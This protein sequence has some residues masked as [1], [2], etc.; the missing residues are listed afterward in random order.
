MLAL[1]SADS[2]AVGAAAGP[3][4]HALHINFTQLGLLVALPA[5]TGAAATV[6]I[7]ALTDRVRRVPLL[8]FSIGLW[9]V[10]MIV[11]GAS[12]SFQMLLLSRLLLGAVTATS[13]PTIASLTGDLFPSLERA[14]IYGFILTGELLGSVVGLLISGNVAGLLSWRF[15]FWV[16]AIPGAALAWMIWRFLPEPVRGGQS[17]L[18]RG[19]TQMITGDPEQLHDARSEVEEPRRTS[20]AM[21]R[22][23]AAQRI[24][25]RAN[26][27]LEAD[28]D[29]MSL[30][31]AVRYVL[32]VP[33]NVALIVVSALGYFF[34]S[35]VRTFAVIFVGYQ[36]SIGQGLAT[37][38]LAVLSVGAVA[39]V[40][41]SGRLAD[42]LVERGH[43]AG[44]LIVAGGAFLLTSVLFLPP[45]L[46]RSLVIGVPF[47]LVATAALSAPNPP[48]DAARLDVMP[49]RLWG[50]AEG[51]RT[52][53]RSVA[54]AFAPLVFGFL[55]DRLGAGSRTPGEQT[56]LGQ[57][58]HA[59]GLRDTF[60]IVLVPLA[61]SG[62]ILLRSRHAYRRDVA[63]AL[64]GEQDPLAGEAPAV[65][66]D[67]APAGSHL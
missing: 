9:S 53:L 23:I 49:A 58:T 4:K 65:R 46:S 59:G 66:E 18:Q 40:L 57:H 50:R 29:H 67:P 11:C 44:R 27:V 19:A 64:A 37:S 32:S 56:S 38:L 15:A 5:L 14:R 43:I 35:G 6:P 48:L 31:Q 28:P 62:L 47:L 60:L 61:L 42:R 3:L 1:N 36:Y 54:Q 55:S 20:G 39:G 41:L 16:L 7:G 51:V 26:L 12:T 30:W 22:A 17:R 34:Q 25:P 33:T 63:T 2:A 13:G 21:Q 52:V 8:A 24:L 10:A 45:L